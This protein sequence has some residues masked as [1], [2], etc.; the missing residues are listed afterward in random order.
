MTSKKEL[1]SIAAE[2]ESNL[3]QRCSPRITKHGSVPIVRTELSAALDRANASNH[4]AAFFWLRLQEALDTAF[5]ASLS[6]LSQSEKR[7]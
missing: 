4:T 1:T 3:E 6:I 7:E 2:V 5:L